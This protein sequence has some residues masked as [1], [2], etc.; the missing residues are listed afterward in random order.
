MIDNTIRFKLNQ[1][2]FL[3]LLQGSRNLE[4]LSIRGNSTESVEI[5]NRP[6]ILTNL[7]HVTLDD[8]IPRNPGILDPILD[9]SRDRL[10]SLHVSGFPEYFGANLCFPAMPNLKYLRL[11]EHAPN[12]RVA[13][14]IV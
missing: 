8:F 11:E 9:N 4:F 5:P 13:L 6:G 14:R 7:T 12:N 1:P 10:Q 3:A 2:R